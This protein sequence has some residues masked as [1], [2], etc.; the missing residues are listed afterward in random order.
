[1]TITYNGIEVKEIHLYYFEI[2]WVEGDE[3]KNDRFEVI[4][5]Y[6]T[7]IMGEQEYVFEKRNDVANINLRVN[8]KFVEIHY[9]RK[10]DTIVFVKLIPHNKVIEISYTTLD[11]TPEETG[12]QNRLSD[13]TKK[14]MQ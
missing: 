3:T 7:F 6:H 10:D 8:D 1:M 11:Y 14:E 9:S 12:E 5:Q 13:E 4:P 2:E